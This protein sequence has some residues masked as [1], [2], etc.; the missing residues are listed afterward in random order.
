MVSSKEL[1]KNIIANCN[2]MLT[3]NSKNLFL[4]I[5]H[6][7]IYAVVSF[8]RMGLYSSTDT[9]VFISEKE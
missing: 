5:I 4:I 6:V 2:R 9:R 8:T 1:K 3:Y 7:A